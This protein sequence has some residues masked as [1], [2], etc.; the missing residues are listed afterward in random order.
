M[1]RI[2]FVSLLALSLRSSIACYKPAM[3]WRRLV[4]GISP[5]ATVADVVLTSSTD[6]YLALYEPRAVYHSSDG[7]ASWHWLGAGMPPLVPLSIIVDEQGCLWVG[8]VDGLWRYRQGHWQLVPQSPSCPLYSLA[9]WGQA[10]L[11]AG[12][13]KG[14][15]ACSSAGCQQTNVVAPV[16]SLAVGQD[17]AC[18]GTAGDGLWCTRADGSWARLDQPQTGI[19]NDV[20]IDECGDVYYVSGGA[21]NLCRPAEQHCTRLQLPADA[22]A[23][24]LLCHSGRLTVGTAGQGIL[25]SQ[26]RGHTWRIAAMGLPLCGDIASPWPEVT[27][28]ALSS[29]SGL[30][31]AGTTDAG[32]YC[33]SD[34]GVTWRPLTSAPGRMIVNALAGSAEGTVYVGGPSGVYMSEVGGQSWRHLGDM[35]QLRGVQALVMTPGGML[36]GTVA[37]V[38]VTR[39]NG[40]HWYLLTGELGRQTIFSLALDPHHPERLYAGCWGNNVLFSADGGM[41]WAPLHNGLE[42]LSVHSLAVSPFTSGVAYVGTVEGVYCTRDDGATWRQCGQGFQEKATVF[43]LLHSTRHERALYAGATDGLYRSDDGGEHWRRV[44]TEMGTV[45]ACLVP[46]RTPDEML[47]GTEQGGVWL[48][49]DEGST[50]Q[51]WGLQGRSVYAL[52]EARPGLILAGTD[53]GLY[54]LDAAGT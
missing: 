15:F 14:L 35:C 28:L 40:S 50:W 52:I 38:Y 49:R 30:L 17:L 1:P 10:S 51:P 32:L 9:Q 5:T 31:L 21:L 8:T 53:D 25:T 27:S 26:D 36:A 4:A 18:A 42:T 41:S 43:S 48:S 3:H 16:L 44:N 29:S 34:D 6:I 47:C 20:G 37:G 39:D 23:R 2:L 46:A 54:R 7:G 12:G 19:V 22:Q 11:L 45:Y 24:V 13:E 33:S